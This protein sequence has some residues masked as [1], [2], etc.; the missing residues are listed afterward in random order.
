MAQPT[1]IAGLGTVLKVKVATVL[2]AI[3]GI[4]SIEGPTSTVGEDE[5]TNLD[6]D[7]R[8]YRPT[9]L[10]SGEINWEMQF[11]GSNATHTV[12][13]GLRDS[14]AVTDFAL[15]FEDGTTY[16]FSGFLS[17]MSFGQMTPEEH[18]IASCKVRV[19]GPIAKS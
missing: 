7:M 8:Y 3:P 2:T 17:E 14:P 4:E 19:S 9:L 16:S 18:V 13:E 6:S 10:D 15:E 12:L 11:D 5:V 1:V